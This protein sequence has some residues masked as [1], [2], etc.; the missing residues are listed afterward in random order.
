MRLSDNAI[1]IKNLL[2]EEACYQ[3]I[4]DFR[5]EGEVYC[6]SCG[7]ADIIKRGKKATETCCQR[8]GCK[9]CGKR[10]DDLSGTVLAGHHQPVSVWVLCLY[11]M[12]LNLSNAQI[13]RELDL[14]IDDTGNMV[15]A[16]REDVA[17]KKSWNP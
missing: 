10:F 14:N 8:Y 1:N 6:P 5:W 13:A 15:R 2:S 4:R 12:G 3:M 16:L 11:F 17:K 7:S 9:G